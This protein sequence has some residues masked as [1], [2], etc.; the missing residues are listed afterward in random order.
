MSDE[1]KKFHL[2]AAQLDPRTKMLSLC[3]NQNFPSCKDEGSRFLSM[4]LKDF[5]IQNTQGEV[6]HEDGPFHEP[7]GWMT[8]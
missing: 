3:Y 8:S 2:I 7:S 4:G 1:R 6:N 5:Y